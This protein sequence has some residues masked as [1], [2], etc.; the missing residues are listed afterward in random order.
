VTRRPWLAAVLLLIFAAGAAAQGISSSTAYYEGQAGW[1]AVRD[2]R[3]QDAA[4]HFAAALAADPRD[5]SLHLG[6]GTA[7]FLLGQLQDAQQSLERALAMAPQ[8]T[9]ASLMLG[10]ILTRSNDTAAAVQVLEAALKYAPGNKTLLERL[11]RVRHESEL[12]ANFFQS[13]GAHFTVLFEGPADEELAR[14]AIEVLEAAYWRVGTAMLTFPERVIPVVLY[15][16][17]QFSDITRSP[18][19]A[20]AAYDGRI[21]V[22]VRGALENPEELDRVLT[23]E[24]THALVQSIAP[25]NVPAWLNEGLAVYFEPQGPAWIDAQL[26]SSNYRM[27]L[28]KLAGG[29][30]GLTGGRARMAYAQS[31]AAV[32]SLMEQAGPQAMT[33][34]LLD[35]GRGE[36]FETAFEQRMLQPYESFAASLD[37]SR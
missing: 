23:H 32:R 31:G 3:H 33:G 16:E 19:W 34:L 10:D 20:A 18:S 27:P 21:K 2:G 12:H 11:E 9:P 24:F 25:R 14:R 37:P 4:T 7:A 1:T 30:G 6:A 36:K 5:P 22:P 15:T 17:Q 8:L 28:Q 29:F 35:L 26:A 13:Q